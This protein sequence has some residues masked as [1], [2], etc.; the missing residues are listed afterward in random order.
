MGFCLEVQSAGVRENLDVK[1]LTFHA[2]VSWKYISVQ[3]K[4]WKVEVIHY[5]KYKQ[6]PLSKLTSLVLYAWSMSPTLL[7]IAYSFSFA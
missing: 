7:S 3:Q 5:K 2:N 4:V 6:Q 1:D